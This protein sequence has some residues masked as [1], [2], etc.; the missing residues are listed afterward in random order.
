MRT[1]LIGLA[2]LLAVAF[3]FS[4]THMEAPSTAAQIVARY[5]DAPKGVVFEGNADGFEPIKT[6]GFD[7][8]KN[9][10]VINGGPLYK[11]PVTTKEFI[12][13]LKSI[14]KDDRL[15]ITLIAGEP[16]TYGSISADDDIAKNWAASD[17]L[18]G[19]I[20]YGREHLLGDIKLPGG[21]TPKQAPNRT[22]PVVAFT[23]FTNYK[24][25]KN[26]NNEYIRAS[27]NVVVVLL[28]LADK[29]TE[30]GGHL[31]DEEAMKN[32]VMEEAD[33]ANI[34]HLRVNQDEYLKIPVLGQSAKYGEAAAFSRT[35]RDLKIDTDKLIDQMK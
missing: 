5:N 8:D 1:A 32:Y 30:D 21:Y 26:Q 29:K 23:N 6:V 35:L 4:F 17:R 25:S 22:V 27:M 12:K 20:V 10:F 11:N 9:A 31:P 18:F 16:H 14:K 34:D 7:K 15:G 19:G 24:F 33:K 28:P 13:I 2:T 3:V